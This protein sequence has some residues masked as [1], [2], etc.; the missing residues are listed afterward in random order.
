MLPPRGIVVNAT[1]PW[2]KLSLVTRT[3]G[4]HEA[5]RA[6]GGAPTNNHLD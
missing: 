1:P 5:R 6:R 4:R 2:L 3:R